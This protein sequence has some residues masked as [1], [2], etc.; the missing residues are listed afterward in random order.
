M[1]APM[2][3]TDA[4]PTLPAHK[5]SRAIGFDNVAMNCFGGLPSEVCE[6]LVGFSH[7]VRVFTTRH[8]RAFLAE[9][10]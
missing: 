1:A 6:G 5:N 4:Y 3:S 8:R 2:T 7:T 10:C 9:R